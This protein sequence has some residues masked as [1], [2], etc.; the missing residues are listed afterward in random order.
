MGGGMVDF[1]PKRKGDYLWFGIT[2][3]MRDSICLFYYNL[4]IEATVQL[5]SLR[6]K[7]CRPIDLWEPR[8]VQAVTALER[9]DDAIW[10]AAN[11]L[12]DVRITFM[13]YDVKRRLQQGE[14]LSSMKN[15]PPG[16]Y[17]L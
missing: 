1:D 2:E 13:R 7:Q 16:C 4:D 8:Q 11:A 12:L 3:R 10:R 14:L 9:Y 6:V 5:P 15:L 17:V